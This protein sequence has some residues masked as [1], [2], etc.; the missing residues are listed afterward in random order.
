MRGGRHRLILVAL[1]LSA[2]PVLAAGCSFESRIAVQL[3]GDSPV[4]VKQTAKVDVTPQRA[5]GTTTRAGQVVRI[6]C[7]ITGIYDVDDPTGPAVLVQLFVVHLRTR[8]LPRG[9]PYELDCAG[10][11]IVELP[12][13]ASTIQ[14]TATTASEMN[15]ELPVQAPVSSIAL[16]FGERLRAEPGTQFTLV[17]Q[18]SLSAGDHTVELTF[19]LPEAGAFREKV[20]NT[21]QVSC[22]RSKYLQ[23]IRP[24][25]TRM[26]GA[27]ALTVELSA[28]ETSISVPHLS[29]GIVAYRQATR[30]L[31]CPRSVRVG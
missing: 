31:S 16:A 8:P 24:L 14:A 1:L 11:V 18:P 17:E 10:P 29:G 30:T 28:K 22:G 12:T 9:T 13:D 7:S 5:R 3:L 21:A 26:A 25:V 4:V 27:R 15:V 19:S 2:L 6:D 20:L 23:P